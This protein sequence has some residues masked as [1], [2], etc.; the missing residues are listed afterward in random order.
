MEALDEFGAPTA[1]AVP[2]VNRPPINTLV[3]LEETLSLAGFVRAETRPLEWVDQP[4]VEGFIQRMTHLGPSQRRLALWDEQSRE[5]FV[6]A[7]RV[8]LAELTPPMF[9]DESEVLAAVGYRR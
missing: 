9:R 8:R 4:D 2:G 6:E 7:M 5:T 1:P 3:Q